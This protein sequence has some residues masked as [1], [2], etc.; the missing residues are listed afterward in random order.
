MTKDIEIEDESI[1]INEDYYVLYKA[2]VDLTKAINRLVEA[3][4]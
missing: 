1:T 3:N 4:G 2:L